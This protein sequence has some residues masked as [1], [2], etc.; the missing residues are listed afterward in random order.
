MC[1]ITDDSRYNCRTLSNLSEVD[2]FEISSKSLFDRRF[3]KAICWPKDITSAVQLES[4][5][6]LS[7]VFFPVV[8]GCCLDVFVCSI[9]WYILQPL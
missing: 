6:V 5:G 1:I 2:M 9:C 8:V 7:P 4:T 3:E